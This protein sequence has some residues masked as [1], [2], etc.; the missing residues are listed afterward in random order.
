[1][2]AEIGVHSQAGAVLLSTPKSSRTELG[3][4]RSAPISLNHSFKLTVIQDSVEYS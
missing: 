1:V 3:Y 4:L 2:R